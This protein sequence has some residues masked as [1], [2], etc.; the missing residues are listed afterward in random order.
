MD[1]HACRMCLMS[2]T[3][4]IDGLTCICIRWVM[5]V[6]RALFGELCCSAAL[7]MQVSMCS[8]VQGCGLCN[9]KL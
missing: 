8:V 3:L 6:V 7:Y 5:F 4:I 2:W 1:A 9:Y